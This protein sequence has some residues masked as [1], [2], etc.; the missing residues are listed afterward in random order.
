MLTAEKNRQAQTHSTAIRAEIAEH[1]A[2]L[3][4]KRNDL[5]DTL[6]THLCSHQSGVSRTQRLQRVKGIGPTVS[7]TLLGALPELGRLTQRQI[8]ALVGLAPLAR[9]SGTMRGKRTIWGGRAHVRH[10]L[11][12]ATLSATRC[13]PV[14][15]RLLR[16]PHARRQSTQGGAHRLHAEAARHL[17]CHDP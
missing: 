10:V 4:R 3:E 16:P 11:Y 12:M 13:N 14:H 17:Q 6:R 15:S 7:A 9:D 2:W 5:D 8:T 1:I